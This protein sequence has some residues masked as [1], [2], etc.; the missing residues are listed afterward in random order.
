MVN[1]NNQ[2]LTRREMEKLLSNQTMMILNAVDQKTGSLE[3][4]IDKL[5]IRINQ[6]FDRL[7]STIDKFL[8]KITD[9]ENEFEIMKL[10][11]NRMKRIIREK[12]GVELL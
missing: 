10:D 11:L 12:L 3:K 5:E 8:K 1:K 2:N 9:L 6:K 7:T 4:R